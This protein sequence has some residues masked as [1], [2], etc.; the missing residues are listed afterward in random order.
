M[1][2][3]ERTDQVVCAINVF[4]RARDYV[5]IDNHLR[6]LELSTLSCEE[7]LAYLHA[8][9]TVTHRLENYDC[10]FKRVHRV[11]VSRGHMRHNTLEGCLPVTPT[12][13]RAL[14]RE[15]TYQHRV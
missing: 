3:D 9:R 1:F 12:K 6:T 7:M 14:K 4:L 8:V 13:V 11:L 10:F 5:A 2:R 15:S